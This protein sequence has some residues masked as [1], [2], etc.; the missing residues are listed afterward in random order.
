MEENG[1]CQKVG[2]INGDLPKFIKEIYLDFQIS[3]DKLQ[4]C[5]K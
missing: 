4:Y 3:F 1:K 2:L 5:L